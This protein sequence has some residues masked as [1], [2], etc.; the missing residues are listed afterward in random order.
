V[1]KLLTNVLNLNVTLKLNNNETLTK[2][3][4]KD[5]LKG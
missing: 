3:K 5:A 4:D 1:P 2:F